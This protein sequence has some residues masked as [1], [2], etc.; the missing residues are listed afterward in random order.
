MNSTSEFIA[1]LDETP[2]LSS[3]ASLR[4]LGRLSEALEAL[5][6]KWPLDEHVCIS[7]QDAFVV[8]SQ[9]MARLR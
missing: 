3:A 8:M 1:Q 2:R 5:P 7:L 9:L 4:S 6:E